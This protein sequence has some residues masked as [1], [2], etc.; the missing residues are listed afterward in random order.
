MAPHFLLHRQKNCHGK[1]H[2]STQY[3][4]DAQ[5]PASLGFS[6][7]RLIEERRTVTQVCC[8]GNSIVRWIS[9]SVSNDSAEE[10][11]CRLPSTSIWAEGDSLFSKQ[12]Q[13]VLCFHWQRYGSR[14]GI[15]AAVS[16]ARSM[17]G[18]WLWYSLK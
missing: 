3:A 2:Y 13:E 17:T 11:Q 18:I 6:A 7:V 10:R 8:T 1:F 12:S 14:D 16:T 9:W 15:R 4:S 5:T